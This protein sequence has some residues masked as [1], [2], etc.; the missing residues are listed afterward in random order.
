MTILHHVQNGSL[1][2]VGRRPDRAAERVLTAP[3]RDGRTSRRPTGRPSAARCC[4]ATACAR[5]PAATPG[6][7]RPRGPQHG[8][9]L[10]AR[11]AAVRGAAGPGGRAPR[12]RARVR[13]TIRRLLHGPRDT[14]GRPLPA[15]LDDAEW[16]RLAPGLLATGP[17]V[18]GATGGSGT[19][20]VARIMRRG[21]MFIGTDLN[22]SEDAL[23]FAAF[24]DRWINRYW[25]RGMTPEMTAE[26]RALVARQ[27]A[28]RESPAQP[29][30]W[31]EP[32]SV[33]LL[34]FLHAASAEPS[35]PARRPRRA[36]HGVLV[37]PDAARQARRGRSSPPGRRAAA[38]AV[39]RAVER[40]EH[41]R[42]RLRRARARRPL[43]AAALRGSVR[44]PGC[45]RRDGSPLLRARGRRDAHRGRG[46]AAPRHLRALAQRGA[47]RW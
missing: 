20:V 28:D 16:E 43:P 12:G 5:S 2:R 35:L 24:S 6:S 29:W 8:V 38:V 18:T 11:R 4:S 10:G 23:D 30:G 42:R 1:A 3:V 9:V 37:E 33:Y 15:G 14:A 36:R 25:G 47:R 39:D 40:R 21:G 41:A 45:R 19:R 46:G 44:R 17:G 32:R 27:A 13:G 26:L 22:V 31:K 7:A 34:P